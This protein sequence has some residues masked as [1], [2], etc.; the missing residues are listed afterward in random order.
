MSIAV[1]VNKSDD[2]T[3]T[4]KSD[5]RALLGGHVYR[6]QPFRASLLVTDELE[7]AVERCRK[8]VKQLAAQ[9]RRKNRR[10]RDIEFDLARDRYLCL[11]SLSTSGPD[12]RNPEDCLRV[13]QIFN[14]PQFLV[15]GAQSGDIVQG[16]LGDCWFM[17]ALA[18]LTT[19][20]DLI[21]KICVE[22]DEKV[23]IYGFIFCRDGE[24][25]DVII[26]DQLYTTVPKWESLAYESKKVYHQDKDLYEKI[27]RKGSKTLFFASSSQENETWVP[28]LEKAYAKLH[29]DYASLNGGYS[30]E[31]I[32]DLTGGI[33][34][35]MNLKDI[36]DKDEF[37]ENDL[38][39]VGRD[40]LFG[41]YY[42]SLAAEVEA[43]TYANIDGLIGYHAYSVL[44]VA[45]YKG[46]RFLN[47]RNPW[48]QSE[49]TGRWSDGSK[50][51][52][53]EW[54]PALQVLDHTFG[55]DGSFIMEYEDFLKTFEFLEITQLFDETWIQ[56]SHWLDV[57]GRPFPCPWQY[58]DVSFTFSLEQDSPAI[59]ILSKADTR[60]WAEYAGYSLWT[61]DFMLFK[62]GEEEPIEESDY[63][64][65]QLVRGVTLMIDLDAG[66]YVLHVRLDRMIQRAKD[67]V[68]TEEIN[69]DQRKISRVRAEWARSK[70]MAANYNH[71]L[72]RDDALVTPSRFSGKDLLELEVE[73]FEKRVAYRKELQTK[74]FP[75]PY[76]VTTNV[77][78]E[79]TVDPKSGEKKIEIIAT[80]PPERS[81]LTITTESD[82][83]DG[84]TVKA[85]IEENHSGTNSKETVTEEN[86]SKAHSD[87]FER[88]EKDEA[89]SADGDK[90]ATVDVEGKDADATPDEKNLEK[91]HSAEVVV[92]NRPKEE[93]QE[94]VD[95]TAQTKEVVES[96]SE[97][98]GG[99]VEGT[100]EEEKDAKADENN[101]M[102]SSEAVPDVKEAIT[103]EDDEESKEKLAPEE[104]TVSATTEENKKDKHREAEKKDGE[105]TR[106]EDAETERKD[107]PDKEDKKIDTDGG[108]R[109][110]DA[111]GEEEKR[112]NIHKGEK[113][114]GADEALRKKEIN[115]DGVTND[116]GGERPK[117]IDA[118]IQ[119][120]NKKEGESAKPEDKPPVPAI[121]MTRPDVHVGITCD[122][123]GKSPVVGVRWKCLDCPNSNY[124][125]CNDCHSARKASKTH[126]TNHKVV[127]LE[128][129]D[130]INYEHTGISCDGCGAVP[131]KGTR[132]A[133]LICSDYDVC[134]ACHFK[135]VHQAEHQMLKLETPEDGEDF[136]TNTKPGDDDNVLLGLRI[137]TQRGAKVNISGQLRH[138]RLLT[139]KSK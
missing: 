89:K 110:A 131:I 72:W 54:L 114:A 77:S 67:F 128:T 100:K 112:K 29:G 104:S 47:I 95:E 19:V 35:I 74:T 85:V 44:K 113:K 130:A 109:K 127:R 111:D 71:K 129:R 65:E 79:T 55:E 22:R 41:C 4:Q 138:G 69:W 107:G 3:K 24:W 81:H 66:E 40:K 87:D 134:D 94:K 46:K 45:E 123:C 126:T 56:S 43:N 115:A 6:Q 21:D 132:W 101:K 48:G 82:S 116:V 34:R 9:C 96:K 13:P 136:V 27:A 119:A 103:S 80:M 139:W 11:N 124:D 17:C 78:A 18:T 97:E 60:F 8:K 135:G 52:T 23:G 73:S 38:A 70:A 122:V 118:A 50:E 39:R 26:D 31:A 68:K 133:C 14:D 106:D 75:R 86:Q 1:E 121:D 12:N 76:T 37:W 15:D 36:L 83:K 49:W 16:Q 84:T 7:K 117:K 5:T 33:T 102:E 61:V 63:A 20:P 98:N 25:V 93:I 99:Q 58:G 64:L 92:E 28:L 2:S 10:Y 42:H 32:E 53:S 105:E 51:W 90:A 91:E 120:D 59:I 108:E 125:L 137:Y 62:K 30:G 88:I 57:I